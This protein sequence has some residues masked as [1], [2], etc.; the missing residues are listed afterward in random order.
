MFPCDLWCI[1]LLQ[2]PP[3]V[4]C[5]RKDIIAQTELF[6]IPQ[7]LELAA[8]HN[9]HRQGIQAE[10]I[11]N[12]IVENLWARQINQNKGTDQALARKPFTLPES[13]LSSCAALQQRWADAIQSYRW[14]GRKAR[15]GLLLCYVYWWPDYLPAIQ[16]QH[17]CV[18]ILWSHQNHP[19]RVKPDPYT[20]RQM[21]TLLPWPFSRL[22]CTAKVPDRSFRSR[23]IESNGTVE[24]NSDY[25]KIKIR[26]AFLEL[27]IEMNL[28]DAINA[29][30]SCTF[31]D[32]SGEIPM[33]RLHTVW[34]NCVGGFGKSKSYDRFPNPYS[35]NWSYGEFCDRRCSVELLWRRFNQVLASEHCVAFYCQASRQYLVP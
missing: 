5:A 6:Q 3:V 21:A 13:L 11:V 8:V 24:T 16:G 30:A 32:H 12:W 31:S 35:A 4:W 33:Y 1:Y 22:S 19:F 7:A 2:D 14:Q 25:T 34:W 9:L 23:R 20:T 18:E 26:Q 27:P 29:L 28:S 17:A 10:V 15:Q